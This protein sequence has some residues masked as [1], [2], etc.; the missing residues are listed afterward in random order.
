MFCV[1]ISAIY[2]LASGCDEVLLSHHCVARIPNHKIRF[3]DLDIGYF[4]VKNCVN[5]SNALSASTG[6]I[7]TVVLD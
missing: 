4:F 2:F 6:T 5:H 3:F 1:A 7:Q